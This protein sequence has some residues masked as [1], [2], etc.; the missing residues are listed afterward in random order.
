[1]RPAST[2][3]GGYRSPPCQVARVVPVAVSEPV[4]SPAV[5]T[6]PVAASLSGQ[7]WVVAVNAWALCG[8]ALA[9]LPEYRVIT[10]ARLDP[11][12]SMVYRSAT[13]LVPMSAARRVRCAPVY[14]LDVAIGYWVQGRVA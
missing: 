9:V 5:V 14:Q 11:A 2:A 10:C 3:S 6:A 7:V 1:V 8:A 12:A 13:P 4:M